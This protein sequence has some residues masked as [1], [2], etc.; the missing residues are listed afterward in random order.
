MRLS[1]FAIVLALAC[2]RPPQPPSASPQTA[3]SSGAQAPSAPMAAA[4]ATPSTTMFVEERP[5]GQQ[6]GTAN[7]P[8]A[9]VDSPEPALAEEVPSGDALREQVR[10]EL[11][12]SDIGETVAIHVSGANVFLGGYVTSD[13]QID[14]AREAV[15]RVPGV[16]EVFTH[17]LRVRS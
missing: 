16:D 11:A 7:E 12:R 17:A 14:A 8:S 9:A 2:A 5:I 15:S 4:P 3:Q 10:A 13:A 1:L 6:Y